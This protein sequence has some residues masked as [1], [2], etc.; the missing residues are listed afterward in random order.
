MKLL[1]KNLNLMYFCLK[2][3]RNARKIVKPRTS[4]ELFSDY[5]KERKLASID[6]IDLSELPQIPG[7]F[8]FLFKTK[9][10][11]IQKKNRLFWK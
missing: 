2:K 7:D 11:K 8:I 1:L 10:K 9:Q 6:Q 3:T 4:T 5:L